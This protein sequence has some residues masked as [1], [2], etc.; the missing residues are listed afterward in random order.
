M[1]PYDKR[2]RQD[3]L[4]VHLEIQTLGLADKMS[5]LDMY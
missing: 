5:I 1:N 3:F 2:K 4:W